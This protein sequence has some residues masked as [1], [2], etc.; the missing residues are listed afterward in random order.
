VVFD[1]FVSPIFILFF[2]ENFEKQYEIWTYVF[3]FCIRVNQ[4]CKNVG[5]SILSKFDN[6]FNSKLREINF[7]LAQ[8]RTKISDEFVNLFLLNYECKY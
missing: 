3:F 4:I 1:L 8:A 5:E 6:I 2:E 7:K